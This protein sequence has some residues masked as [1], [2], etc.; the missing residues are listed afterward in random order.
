[1]KIERG[2]TLINSRNYTCMVY[3]FL[4]DRTIVIVSGWDDPVGDLCLK[5]MSILRNE[6]P[7]INVEGKG[8]P[9][10]IGI[11]WY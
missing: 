4:E 1:M 8:Y 2:T 9:N 6:G 3:G 10:C 5:S 7:K 11:D